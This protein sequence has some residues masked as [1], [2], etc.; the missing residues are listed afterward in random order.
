MSNVPFDE[1]LLSTEAKKIQAFVPE[2]RWALQVR[3]PM[4]QVGG[5]AG[6]LAVFK[7]RTKSLR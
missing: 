1:L 4:W 6:A 3:E 2:H 7:I 5:S